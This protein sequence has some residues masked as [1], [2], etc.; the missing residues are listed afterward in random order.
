[1]RYNIKLWSL[2]YVLLLLLFIIIENKNVIIEYLNSS[3]G[4]QW[5][6]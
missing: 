5:V 2:Q 4:R 6:Y 3:V 1:M